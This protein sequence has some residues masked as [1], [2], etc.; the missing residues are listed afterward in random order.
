MLFR[1]D[2][3]EFHTKCTPGGAVLRYHKKCRKHVI[4]CD[5]NS[6]YSM[7]IKFNTMLCN[8]KATELQDYDIF[9][10]ERGSRL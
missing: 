6:I 8:S 10:M 1:K 7:A 2:R 4:L 5:E 3:G 9:V